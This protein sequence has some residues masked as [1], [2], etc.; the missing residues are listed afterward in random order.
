[1]SALSDEYIK[2]FS[3][4]RKSIFNKRFRDDYDPNMSE[5]SNIIRILNEMRELGLADGGRIGLK[6]GLGSFETSDPKEAMKEVVKR[7]LEKNIQTTTVPISENIFLNL[8]PGVS[9]VELGGIMKILGGDLF[10]G[11]SKDK[12]IGFNFKKEFNKGGRVAYQE[13]TPNRELYETPVTDAI[14]SVNEKTIDAIQK[15][16]ELVDKYTG[17]DQI[18]A[19]NFPGA[20]DEASGQ[21]SDFRHQAASNLL[22]EALG[23]GKAG[24]I[25]YLS[26]AIGASGLGAIKEIGDL[27]VAL[28]DNPKNY[29]DAFSEFVKDNVSNIKG[30]F[31][32]N[33]TSQELYDELMAGYVPIDPFAIDRT[34]L[35]RSQQIFAQRKKALEDA[36]KKQQDIKKFIEQK[37]TTAPPKKPIKPIKTTKPE[38]GGGDGGFT[39]TTTAQNV[40]RTES[41]VDSSGNV[42]AYGL[43]KGGLAR[44]LGE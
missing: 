2:N 40:A 12:G 41:R 30:A 23:K 28:Y 44:M 38:T 3:K 16:G 33:K 15:G 26:G 5:R 34:S 42:K 31:A 29:K 37:D 32:K 27:A 21:P 4:E 8:A 43:A 24:P 39:P 14:K 25:G 11:A 10:F 6:E 20:F 36:K 1:M 9:D 19:T 7:F 17:I 13:G 18:T 22:A 35:L